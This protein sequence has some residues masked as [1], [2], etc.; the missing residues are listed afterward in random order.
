MRTFISTKEVKCNRGWGCGYVHIP[1]GHPILVQLLGFENSYNYLQPDGCLQEITLSEWDF[2][3]GFYT[4]GFDTGHS[5]N[6]D[7]HDEDY[8]IQEVKKIK[9]IVDSYTDKD[10]NDYALK[11]IAEVKDKFKEYLL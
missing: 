2:S 1:K 8:V 3:K 4:I 11:A 6:D 7:S 10:A 9:A 5:W